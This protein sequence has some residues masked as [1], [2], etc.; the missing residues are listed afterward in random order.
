MKTFSSNRRKSV[1]N[2]GKTIAFLEIHEIDYSNLLIWLEFTRPTFGICF[3][4][5][6]DMNFYPVYRLSRSNG[7]FSR[8][9]SLLGTCGP[10]GSR[11]APH[12]LKQ[13]MSHFEQ[14]PGDM[15]LLGPRCGQAGKDTSPDE[16]R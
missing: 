12:I 3:A 15:I 16:D 8:I 2:K 1:V 7:A 11:I 13:L 4:F 6:P 14:K 10:Y 5:Y 9:G